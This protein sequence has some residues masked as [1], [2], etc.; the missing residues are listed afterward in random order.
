MP[1][2]ACAGRRWTV[3]TGSN[4]L[5]ALNAAGLRV[6]YSCRAGSCQ[7][8]M[9]RCRGGEP[10]DARPEALP[11]TQ[12]EQGWRLACQCRID[13]DLLV[14][15]FDPARDGLAAQVQAVDWLRRDVLRLRLLPARPLRY[16]AGQHLLLWTPDGIAR[17]YSL[18]S[19]PDDDRWL[20]FHLDC[21]R[22]GAFSEA[23]R[24][25]HPGDGLRLGQLH[26]GAL[27]YDP[28][29]AERPLLLLASGTGLAPLWAVLR[30]T[31]R[32]GHAGPIR[33]LHRTHGTSYLAEPLLQLAQQHNLDV[34]WFDADQP[35][36]D[37]ALRIASRQEIA[38]VCGHAD[39]VA[40]C[41]RR[42]F[43]AGL[44]RGQV[45][46]DTFIERNVSGGLS[47]G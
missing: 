45:F 29:W 4:L 18:A 13:G 6:P 21:H 34:Q 15:L 35:W 37:Q 20:E 25:L 16:R 9:V 24:R 40:A 3:A 2:L 8:C 27:H 39:F 44:P 11:A 7:A 46:S 31:L 14:E 5:D 42:L 33:L 17:P 12:R 43:L 41:C 23:A 22:P 30:E 1:E 38:L 36:N 10:L 19:L 26:G 47:G 32:Q 28:D